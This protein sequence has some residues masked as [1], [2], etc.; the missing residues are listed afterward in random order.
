MT[1][2][3]SLLTIHTT[4]DSLMYGQLLIMLYDDLDRR[5]TRAAE[6]LGADHARVSRKRPRKRT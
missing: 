2:T 3:L 4:L 5:F 1:I 6:R